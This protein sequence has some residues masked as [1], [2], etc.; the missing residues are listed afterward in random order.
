MNIID[1]RDLEPTL[2]DAPA[3]DNLLS[4]LVDFCATKFA[5]PRAQLV[6]EFNATKHRSVQ[7]LF[8]LSFIVI[9]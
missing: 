9:E 6:A 5:T 8:C 7:W 2:V 1:T 4:Q 3:P